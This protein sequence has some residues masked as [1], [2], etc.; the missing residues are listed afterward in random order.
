[1][2][3][4]GMQIGS[5]NLRWCFTLQNLVLPKHLL[6][7]HKFVT[8]FVNKQSWIFVDI[9]LLKLLMTNHILMYFFLYH[10]HVNKSTIHF[11]AI[12]FFKNTHWPLVQSL[13]GWNEDWKRNRRKVCLM[14]LVS[15]PKPKNQIASFYPENRPFG[16]SKVS[17]ESCFFFQ[18]P[19]IFLEAFAGSFLGIVRLRWLSLGPRNLPTVW[20]D[21]SKSRTPR[22]DL[23]TNLN[24]MN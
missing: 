16:H 20:T 12:K 14:N 5:W 17:K 23:T 6:S 1:M 4:L 22:I 11:C 9:F 21:V 7:R 3:F 2:L 8:V 15:L 24:H 13:N 10:T 19:T 18:F